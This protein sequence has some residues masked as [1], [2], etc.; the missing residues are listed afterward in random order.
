MQKYR[1]NKGNYLFLQ[2]LPS[3]CLLFSTITSLTSK[4]SPNVFKSCLK[5]ISLEKAMI[6]TYLQKL[7]RIWEIWAN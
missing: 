2:I 7:P 6:L 1:L 3:V 5:M 4:K